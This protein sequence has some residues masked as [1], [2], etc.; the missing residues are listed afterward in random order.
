M[1][2]QQPVL[3]EP[4]YE[5]GQAVGVRGY[6]IGNDI[7]VFR[8]PSGSNTPQFLDRWRGTT[9]TSINVI[10]DPSQAFQSG[11]RLYAVQYD[12]ETGEDSGQ[13]SYRDAVEVQPPPERYVGADQGTRAYEEARPRIILPLYKCMALVDVVNVVHGATVQVQWRSKEDSERGDEVGWTDLG[14]STTGFSS[15]WVRAR[16]RLDEGWQLRVRQTLGS[17]ESGWFV[18]EDFVQEYDGRL[19]PP[20]IPGPLIECA[21]SFV[22]EETEPAAWVCIWREDPGYRGN[23]DTPFLSAYAGRSSADIEVRGGLQQ[24][25]VLSATQEYCGKEEDRS[26]PSS[27][28]VAVQSIEYL[29]RYAESQPRYIDMARNVVEVDG[30][31][32]STLSVEG[33]TPEGEEEEIGSA[34]SIGSTQFHTALEPGASAEEVMENYPQVRVIHS[35][36]C[37]R[38]GTGEVVSVSFPSD[39]VPTETLIVDEPL[40]EEEQSVVVDAHNDCRERFRQDAGVSPRQCP[41]LVWSDELAYHAQL[42]ANRLAA[43]DPAPNVSHSDRDT[44][45]GDYYDGENIAWDLRT[46]A[47]FVAFLEQ[48]WC[49][50][51]G[52]L[53]FADGQP[54]IEEVAPREVRNWK[55][56]G[57]YTQIVWSNTSAI[58]VGRARTGRGRRYWVCQFRPGGNRQD[59]WPHGQDPRT[60]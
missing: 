47:D 34:S 44:Q 54:P 1:S 6:V 35:L 32:E 13:V 5:G 59:Q 31:H 16:P 10:L 21:P 17:W 14:T 3:V 48:D 40:D 41:D 12:R 8:Y 7:R 50:G 43:I 45:R 4:L 53:Y 20:T 9:R 2:L 56:W 36:R 27:P 38:E 60:L 19:D 18:A 26:E 29:E 33:I 57:H 58:G 46:V 30:L 55:V 42:Y 11:D 52:G 15:T 22:V 37:T 49:A 24:G 23:P 28:G 25:W 39:P 51:E